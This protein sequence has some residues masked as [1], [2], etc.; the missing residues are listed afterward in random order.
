MSEAPQYQYSTEKGVYDVSLLDKE[1]QEL[2]K[3][4]AIADS[5]VT[6]AGQNL[7]IAQASVIAINNKLQEVLTDEALITE[8]DDETTDEE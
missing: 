4:L 6:E 1:G 3:L 7:G 5:R 2:F 8:K